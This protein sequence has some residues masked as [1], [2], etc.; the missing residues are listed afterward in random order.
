MQATRAIIY[1]DN[2]R[3]N[4]RLIKSCI[5][6]GTKICAAVKA[7]AYGHGVI[8][9][10]K[11]A[12]EEGIFALSVATSEEAALLR[13]TGFTCPII[14]LALP[15]PEEYKS[16]IENQVSLLLSTPDQV[17]GV[18]RIA[19]SLK[20]KIPIHLDIDTGMNRTG[21]NPSEAV[22]MAR[23]ILSRNNLI[24][25]GTATHFAESEVYDSPYTEEQINLFNRTIGELKLAGINPGIVHAGN[26]GTILLHPEAHYDMVRPG[27]FLYGYPP[28]LETD[29]T[30]PFRPVMELET[31]IVLIKEVEAGTPVSYGRTYYT[32]AKTRIATITVGYG[33]GYNRLLSNKASVLINGRL[34]PQ[35]GRVCMD[36]IMVDLGMDGEV[37]VN[38]TVIL[39]GPDPKGP[40]AWDIANLAT[41]IPYEITCSINKRVPRIYRDKRKKD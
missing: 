2:L 24:L 16:L 22:S 35:V 18:D 5:K 15:M 6:P 39:F 29:G 31:R 38:D 28:S 40:S 41:T 12:L 9:V 26:S 33:D 4:I 34:Y 32:K 25:E 36:Q 13:E 1:L 37:S 11:T 3:N 8:P 27:I 17:L 23:E 30:L 7:D 10:S 14:L 19:G 21:C 20:K